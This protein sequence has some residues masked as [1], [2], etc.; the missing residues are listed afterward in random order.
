[1]SRQRNAPIRTFVDPRV[2][3]YAP[4]ESF[5]YYRVVGYHQD[6]K[7]AVNTSGGSTLRKAKAK[8]AEVAR[9]LRRQ[10]TPDRR[11]PAK[12]LVASEIELW[13][14]PANHRSRGNKPWSGR[15]AENMRREWDLRVAPLLSPRAP[16]S[17]LMDKHFWIQVLNTAQANGLAPSSVQKTGQAC[18]SFVTWLM[19]RGLLDRNPMHGVSYSMTK[20]DNAGMDPKAVN[21]Q[22]IPNLDMVYPLGYWLARLAW[23]GRPDRGGSRMPDAVSPQGRGLQPMLVAMTGLRN[24]EMFALR[25]SHVDLGALE[26][27][28]ETQLVEED[29]G[30]RFEAPPKHGSIRTVT[31][32]AFLQE[33]LAAM[34]EHRRA[35]S[36]ED[37]PILFCSPSGGWEGRR[38]HTRRFR[39]A[40]RRS[41]WPDHLTWYGLRHLY[42]VTMLERLPLEIVSRLMGHHSPDFTAKRYLSLRMGWLDQARAVAQSFEP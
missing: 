41:G 11:D 5:A 13:L 9:Q 20:A 17:E 23:P 15:H 38:N 7:R 26:I 8:A 6:G 37:D 4:T 3:V 14:D 31:F 35:W 10:A 18:R 12:T 19:D 33:D 30:R 27:R 16:V 2:E 42:A 25:P 36:G 1:M 22:E 40:A 32:A 39:N 34:I 24:G 28:I 29:S 21:P